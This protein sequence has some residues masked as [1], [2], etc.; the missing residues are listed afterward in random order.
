M[1]LNFRYIS[2]VNGYEAI[3]EIALI[4]ALGEICKYIFGMGLP[5]FLLRSSDTFSMQN[6][7]FLLY[8]IL[9]LT[10]LALTFSL[11][12]ISRLQYACFYASSLIL[13]E[14][15]SSVL[16]KRGNYISAT[17][18]NFV[19][20]I[21]LFSLAYS[22]GFDKHYLL[23]IFGVYNFT[24]PLIYILYYRPS[25]G[26]VYLNFEYRTEVKK[27][28]RV[29]IIVPLL[30]WLFLYYFKV[31]LENISSVS[32]LGVF[33]S[34]FKLGYSYL[35]VVYSGLMV[36]Y[37]PRF[38]GLTESI[39][40]YRAKRFIYSEIL[41]Q[42]KVLLGFALC[43]LLFFDPLWSFLYA[44]KAPIPSFNLLEILVGSLLLFVSESIAYIWF[45][46]KQYT[47]FLL[48]SVF[49]L[50]PP[51]LLVFAG[52]FFFGSF[53]PYIVWLLVGIFGFGSCLILWYIMLENESGK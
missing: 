29:M 16:R 39:S 20:N 46:R 35:L 3:G 38:L 9:L 15:V 28:A 1:A 5:I 19:N 42:L 7:M 50:L 31:A 18:S 8:I 37:Q 53:N 45:V 41:G 32:E 21:A 22:I 26:F 2:I 27:N 23:L 24:F 40:L 4:I 30:S 47:T 34:A 10:T 17:L 12:D 33:E 48:Y 11:L 51:T 36:G 44:Q 13:N 52:T 25:F 14:S 6:K 43:L 49:K